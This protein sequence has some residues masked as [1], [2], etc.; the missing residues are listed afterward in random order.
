VIGAEYTIGGQSGAPS[1]SELKAAGFTLI[2]TIAYESWDWSWDWQLAK[3]WVQNAH[4]AG[5]R[6]LIDTIT[7]SNVNNVAV[8]VQYA[9][10]IGADVI[11]LDEVLS[12]FPSMTQT[13]LQA[14]I[15]AGRAVNPNLQCY[16]NEWDPTYI[17]R[18]Y[19][20]TSAYPYV[21]VA[22]DQ[23]NDKSEIDY[24]IQL[25][26]QYGK[27]PAAWL[28]FAKGVQ[29]YDCWLHLDQ[30]LAY[31]KTKNIEPLFWWVDA[32]G[33]WKTEWSQVVAYTA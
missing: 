32:A 11:A 22:E 13:Q 33:T 9:A 28:I 31:A 21:R 8:M 2:G 27:A 16:I 30:W 7:E 17:T 3:T 5:F 23:Y 12:I 10:Q 6:V 26:A 25:G 19:Q 20:W 18:A 4:A 15:N 14:A 29:D 1:F 24:N